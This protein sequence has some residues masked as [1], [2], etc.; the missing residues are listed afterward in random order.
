[1]ASMCAM[2][3]FCDSGKHVA[4]GVHDFALRIFC[5]IRGD[6]QSDFGH[7]GGGNEGVAAPRAGIAIQPAQEHAERGGIIC[8][9]H[10][11]RASD[12][13]HIHRSAR[14]GAANGWQCQQRKNDKE[15]GKFFHKAIP[16]GQA[17]FHI[18]I[19]WASMGVA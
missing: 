7:P 14:S 17:C 18:V 16:P 6:A 9:V 19:L 11:L 3:F 2:L 8:A 15:K 12:G 13:G 5:A 4:H 10:Y 1:M